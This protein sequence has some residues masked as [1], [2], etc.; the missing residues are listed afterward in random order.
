M[1]PRKIRLLKAKNVHFDVDDYLNRIVPPSPLHKFP[2]WISWFLG[3]RRRPAEDPGNIIVA[4]WALLG[5]F[6]GLLLVAAVFRYSPQFNNGH[7]PPVIFASLGAAAVLEYGAIQSPLAQPRNTIIGHLF[8]ALVGVAISKLFKLN[9]DFDS[10]QWIAAPLACGI[11]SV[12][13]ILTNTVHPPGGATAILAVADVAI[14]GLGWFFVPMI[15]VACLL[16]LVVG[17]LLNN[18]Q[19]QYP[20]YWWTPR[21]VGVKANRNSLPGD[22]ETLAGSE[23]TSP[24]SV[25]FTG[26]H[27]LNQCIVLGPEGITVPSDFALLEDELSALREILVRLQYSPAENSLG[28]GQR[29]HHF[30]RV[31]KDSQ[32]TEPSPSELGG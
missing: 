4:G 21:E 6:T 20:T 5:A 10:L 18:I 25:D 1:P 26:L 30:Y 9:P 2:K 15:L 32:L 23:K 17:L 19:R 3:Y 11:A 13:M 8:S 29:G 7:V 14:E 22:L 27:H 12:V 31:D 16:M 28:F 24:G